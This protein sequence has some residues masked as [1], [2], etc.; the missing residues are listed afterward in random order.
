[1]LHHNKKD[2]NQL[3]SFRR[4]KINK[5]ILLLYR[6][7][8]RSFNRN[9][10]YSPSSS[11]SV[12][13]KVKILKCNKIWWIRRILPFRCSLSN[14]RPQRQKKRVKRYNKLDFP[15]KKIS[16]FLVNSSNWK[17]KK[18]ISKRRGRRR[19]LSSWI[20][21]RNNYRKIWFCK[22]WLGKYRDIIIWKNPS[23]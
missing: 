2:P 11:K 5:K 7:N 6:V 10:Y 19:I 4:Q 3:S 23:R 15:K 1:M 16:N 9:L 21:F 18:K 12:Y 20:W 22:P 17:R 13:Q 14:I 8:Q